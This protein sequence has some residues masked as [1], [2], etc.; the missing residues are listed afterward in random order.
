LHLLHARPVFTVVNCAVQK[1]RLRALEIDE[2]TSFAAI[3]NN[4]GV[5]TIATPQ[6]TMTRDK[7]SDLRQM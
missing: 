4:H 7:E 5:F 6:A 1:L 3:D 2:V